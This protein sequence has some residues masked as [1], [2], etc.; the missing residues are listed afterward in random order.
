MLMA[1]MNIDLPSLLSRLDWKTKQRL[2]QP[3]A[4]VLGPSGL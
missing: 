4:A 2:I 1:V 3:G